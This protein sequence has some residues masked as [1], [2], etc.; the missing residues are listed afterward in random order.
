MKFEYAIALTGNI[1]TGKSTV[2]DML[3]LDGFY[4]I[5]ADK[6]ASASLRRIL[7]KTGLWF[8]SEVCRQ[9]IAQFRRLNGRK[10]SLTVYFKLI[11]ALLLTQSLVV[12]D[13]PEGHNPQ[14]N[15]W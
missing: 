5:D 12:T 13:A 6:N 1:A 15:A 7:H 3:S 8:C 11:P 2:A 9:N 10:K 14:N 4:L